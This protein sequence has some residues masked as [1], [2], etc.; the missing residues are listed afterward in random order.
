MSRDAKIKQRLFSN[1]AKSPSTVLPM[2]A[3]GLLLVGVWVGLPAVLVLGAVTCFLVGI[4]V[5]TTRLIINAEELY[6]KAL[7]E[8]QHEDQL[9]DESSLDE[10]DR[11]LVSDRD[12]RTENLLRD[13]RALIKGFNDFD[14][15]KG[16][17]RGSAF[18]VYTNV[19]ALFRECVKNLEKTLELFNKAQGLRSR[20]A[21]KPF[22]DEREKII[23]E[24]KESV[25]KMAE[26]LTRTQQLS[27][28]DSSCE[29]NEMSQRREDLIRALQIAEEARREVQ[30]VQAGRSAQYKPED[31]DNEGAKS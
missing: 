13:L 12:S 20:E 18:R 3:G 10:L 4:G 21:K 22:V 16:L 9:K 2:T 6:K 19:E 5:P 28:V 26:V 17:D 8:I 31:Y 15:S 24:V 23:E 27:S 14:W 29:S 7:A 25:R 30:G 1:L 11:A